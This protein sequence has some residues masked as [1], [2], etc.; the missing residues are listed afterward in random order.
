MFW[1]NVIYRFQF[2]DYILIVKI[3]KICLVQ[4]LTL[5]IS[6]KQFLPFY[7]HIP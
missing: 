5:I 2:Y 7:R 3:G 6:S 4:S 1:T